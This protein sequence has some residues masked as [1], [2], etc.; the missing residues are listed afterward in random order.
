[1]GGEGQSGLRNGRRGSPLESYLPL[2]YFALALLLA[3]AVL[4]SI[5]RRAQPATSQSASLNPDAPP[6][7]HASSIIASFGAASGDSAGAGSGNG[8][9]PVGPGE[10]TG[11][12]APPPT[13]LA[14]RSCVKGFGNPPRQTFSLY[15][16]PCAP[17]FTGNNGGAT[18]KGVYPDEVRLQITPATTTAS[19]T[20][21]VPRTC[22]PPSCRETPQDRTYRVFQQWLNQNFQ[23]YGRYLQLYLQAPENN[24]DSVSARG[25]A[26]TAD[27]TYHVFGITT[28]QA[29]TAEEGIRRKLMV[30]NLPWFGD[31]YYVDHYPYAFSWYAGGTTMARFQNE[32]ICKQLRDKPVS[33][34]DDPALRGKPRVYGLVWSEEFFVG[35]T[36]QMMRDDLKQQCGLDFARDVSYSY[37]TDQNA[38]GLAQAVTT[39]HA[40]GV[41]TIACFCDFVAPATLTQSATQQAYFPEWIMSGVGDMDFNNNGQLYDQRQW[42]HAI[43]LSALETM[44]PVQNR[45]YY[46]AFKEIDPADNPDDTIGRY[47][48][49]ELLMF[50]NGIQLAGPNLTPDTMMKGL[51]KMPTRP[52][53][54]AWAVAGGFGPSDYTYGKYVA[55]VWW[56]PSATAPDDGSVGAY[57]YVLGS[58]RFARGE[59][60]ASPVGFFTDGVTQV[61][62]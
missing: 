21:R 33:F 42:G 17:A 49:H 59:I 34:T 62:R 55:L 37:F 24:G 27:E 16:A 13:S 35:V 61:S 3:L 30:G 22:D 26:I 38:S 43:G 41:T 58:K 29:P 1:M 19:Y 56:D 52:P 20:G 44:M 4:P 50:A 47:I 7:K 5:L 10:G 54:P 48:F 15:S 18:Y 40:A 46:Q 39:M 28:S 12:G 9:A 51:L 2:G 60:P 36:G 57:R 25:A 31:Q 23:F 45:D 8:G 14:P 32:L 6:D 53:D 11:G